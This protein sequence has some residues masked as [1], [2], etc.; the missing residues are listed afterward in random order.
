LTTSSQT[1]GDDFDFPRET[2]KA[3]NGS[4]ILL[5][6]AWSS[7]HFFMHYKPGQIASFMTYHTLTHK[8]YFTGKFSAPPILQHLLNKQNNLSFL[9]LSP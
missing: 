4:K 5:S 1:S 2:Q 8:Y 7:S 3:I 6:Q 9:Y